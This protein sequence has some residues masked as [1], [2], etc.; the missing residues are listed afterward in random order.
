V[1]HATRRWDGILNRL[2]PLWAVLFALLLLNAAPAAPV[3]VA[4]A[5]PAPLDELQSQAQACE[6]NG[7]WVG[8]CHKYDD[9][10]RKDRGNVEAREAY[11]RCLRQYQIVRRH[12]D[13]VYR[14]ALARLSPSDALDIY[15]SVLAAIPT[16]YVDRDKTEI[17][18]LFKHGV[19]EVRYALNQEAFVRE[20]LKGAAASTVEAFKSQLAMWPDRKIDKVSD[21]RNLILALADLAYGDK[22]VQDK[23]SFAVVLALEFAFGACTGLDEYTLYLTPQHY[24]TIRAAQ[25]GKF[26]GVGIDLAFIDQQLEVTH[27]YPN[28]PAWGVLQEHD[29]IVSIDRHPV[30]KMR[31]E[32]V[33]ELLR[34]KPDSSVNLEIA[35]R[36][37]SVKLQRKPVVIPSVQS[38][39]LMDNPTEGNFIG[40]VKI[41][42]FQATTLKEMQEALADLQSQGIKGLILDLRGNPGGSFDAAKE[43]S[44]LFLPEGVIVNTTSQLPQFKDKSFRVKGS[45]NPVSL[46]VCVLVD[47]ETA[48]S[49]ELLAGA[50]KDNERALL[51]GQTTF[52]KGS[53][54]GIIPLKKDKAL[55][56]I[57]VTIAKF[58][59]PNKKEYAN[60]GITPDFPLDVPDPIG[61]IAKW[62]RT[63]MPKSM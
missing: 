34:G 55:G 10:I 3:N 61:H 20:H 51:F 38:Y 62:M 23:A 56:G 1:T 27:I 19:Q 59:S 8:A 26:V 6:R 4:L 50:L 12:S 17:N 42:H 60:L 49:A 28:S 53:I 39:L 58:T 40:V 47:Y 7:D 57:R 25:E 44:E 15:E 36:P 29:R 63:M 48:S 31:P 9:M 21:A 54:Q 18:V 52:G 11:H 2:L 30:D 43:V 14:E 13:R 41:T 45:L 33:A 37:E 5:A 35:G 32:D 46:P 16:Y 22:V 24:N